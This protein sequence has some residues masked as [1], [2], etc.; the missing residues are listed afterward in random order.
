MKTLS[1]TTSLKI[2]ISE[3]KEVIE[4]SNE[5]KRV[6]KSKC[7]NKVT[8][9]FILKLLEKPLLL[10]VPQNTISSSFIDV[11]FEQYAHNVFAIDDIYSI[12]F[13]MNIGSIEQ[14]LYTVSWI[15]AEAPKNIHTIQ[16]VKNLVFMD[17]WLDRK[18]SNGRMDIM[19]MEEDID[20]RI[21][22]NKIKSYLKKPGKYFFKNLLDL[23]ISSTKKQYA[24]H[25]LKYHKSPKNV[26]I[27]D[28]DYKIVYRFNCPVCNE[29]HSISLGKGINNTSTTK[30]VIIKNEN[31]NY[32]Q[33][34]CGHH[35]TVYKNYPNPGFHA[36][37]DK[38]FTLKT[39]ED[40]DQAFLFIYY[41]HH[42]EG[43]D[44]I[45]MNEEGD[46]IRI[47]FDEY[48]NQLKDKT[49]I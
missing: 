14:Q 25:N 22:K 13:L 12:L 33:F 19:G 36:D 6:E 10:F 32:I 41:Q 45:A 35:K 3:L 38:W 4:A 37:I 46:E 17:Y 24:S 8:E 15:M 44:I 2:L 34:N 1:G 11:K 23:Q 5:Y 7:F 43:D 20:K 21:N 29:K 28:K 49:T 31:N 42:R 40:Y 27:T 16:P 47:S 30:Q 18:G 9:A 26:V 39:Q 48:I